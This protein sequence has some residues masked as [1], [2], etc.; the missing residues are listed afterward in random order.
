MRCG[1]RESVDCGDGGDNEREDNG[2]NV[3]A[4]ISSREV[5]TQPPSSIATAISALSMS[6]RGTVFV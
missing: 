1:E 4:E 2:N 5:A 3:H 6:G